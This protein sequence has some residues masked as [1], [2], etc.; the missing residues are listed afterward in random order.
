MELSESSLFLQLN[1]YSIAIQLLFN[2]YRILDIL[3]EI[4][5]SFLH[6]VEAAL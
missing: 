2:Y 3:Q 5:S 6:R 4:N 1:C